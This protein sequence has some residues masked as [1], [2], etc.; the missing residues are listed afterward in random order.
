MKDQDPKVDHEFELV[1]VDGKPMQR[2]IT[3]IVRVCNSHV[4]ATEADLI[5]VIIK[6]TGKTV[7]RCKY[8][9]RT[10]HENK[11]M[12]REELKKDKEELPDYYVMRTL[13]MGK[14]GIKVNDLPP[15]LIEAKRAV[16]K[17]KNLTQKLEEPLKT[18]HKHGKLYQDDLIKSGKSRWTDEQQW[19]CKQCM[20][21][22][23]K[24]NYELNKLKINLKSKHYRTKNPEKVRAIKLVSRR[25]KQDIENQKSRERWEKWEKRNPGKVQEMNRK[26]KKIAHAELNDSY[27]KQNIVKRTGLKHDEIPQ[28]LVD[29]KRAVMMLKRQVKTKRDHE[30][31]LIKLEE[32]ESV[33][34][35]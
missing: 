19:K 1:H 31:V 20:K 8:C 32:R 17:I 3:N 22:M 30:K 35:K 27:I 29:A 12:R 33:K 4:Y 2:I 18:C 16:M 28:L 21:D 9:E 10:K 14:S 23:H 7:K 13:R 6:T 26:V 5:D 11:K 25:K 24:R 34:N 15:A